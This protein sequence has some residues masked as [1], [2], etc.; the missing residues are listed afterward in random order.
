VDD[1]KIK[2]IVW[3]VGGAVLGLVVVLFLFRGVFT[4]PSPSVVAPNV[5]AVNSSISGAVGPREALLNEAIQ[6]CRNR[7]AIGGSVLLDRDV[8]SAIARART[9]CRNN[10]AMFGRADAGSDTEANNAVGDVY[11]AMIN[12]QERYLQNLQRANQSR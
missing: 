3:Q 1:E 8:Q 6:E 5:G 10:D 9:I 2:D 11:T 4:S 12:V 7:G